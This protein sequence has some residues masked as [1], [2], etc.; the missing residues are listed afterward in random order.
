M[1]MRLA[2]PRLTIN[3]S[4]DGLVFRDI[5]AYVASRK[6]N[7]MDLTWIDECYK[8]VNEDDAYYELYAVH[9]GF[10]LARFKLLEDARRAAKAHRT[11][12]TAADETFARLVSLVG[13]HPAT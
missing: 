13:G 11:L 10:P 5:I 4:G 8:I 2:P 6:G 9:S 7:T 3:S 1:H 12:Y